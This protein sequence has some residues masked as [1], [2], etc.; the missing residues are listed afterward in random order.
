M[1][2]PFNSADVISAVGIRLG[3]LRQRVADSQD[4]VAHRLELFE[5]QIYRGLAEQSAEI[6]AALAALERAL[7]DARERVASLKDG[8]PGLPGRDGDSIVG[9][10]GERGEP[11]ASI[12][13]PPGPQGPP[14]EGTAG[15]A[16]ER[17]APGP[18]GKFAA[19]KAWQRGVHYESDL[20]AHAGSSWC[21]MRDTAEEPPHEDWLCIAQ[22]GADGRTP[23][24]RGAWKAASAY[25]ELD[26]VMCD[27]S[28][29]IAQRDA[30]GACPGDSWRLLAS[31]GKSGPPGA[32]GPVG[33]RGYPG[34]PGPLPEALAVDDE[35]LL[36]L[37]YSDGTQLDCDLYP[38]LS[39][40]AR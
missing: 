34:P 9:P 1:N 5:A 3:E 24:F 37:R 26:V 12:E 16:G 14:G 18:P 38:L 11:G 15:P 36:T 4:T 30:P 2:E 22:R 35:G 23:A 21:A 6:S 10:A 25:E 31:R 27:G 8:E 13:G 20:V 19:A 29:F 17:G 28:S 33:E 7:S 39:R 32:V 40:I